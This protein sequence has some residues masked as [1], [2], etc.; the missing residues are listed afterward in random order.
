MPYPFQQSTTN[1]GAYMF[2]DNMPG[3]FYPEPEA[4]D[5]SAVGFGNRAFDRNAQMSFMDFTI[6]NI[7]DWNWG[8]LGSLLGNEGVQ[9]PPGGG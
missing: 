6:N 1:S 7:Q 4:G 9:P 3:R 2:A 8:D 5:N